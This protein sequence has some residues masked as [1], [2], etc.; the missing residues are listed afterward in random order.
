[1][2]RSLL[3]VSAA[4]SLTPSLMPNGGFFFTKLLRK[5]FCDSVARD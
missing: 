3:I 4:L 2:F 5:L 1:M